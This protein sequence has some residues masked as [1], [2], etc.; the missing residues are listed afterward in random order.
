MRV[1]WVLADAVTSRSGTNDSAVRTIVLR[2]N[3]TRG[4]L[5]HLRSPAASKIPMNENITVS[6]AKPMSGI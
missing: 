6:W 4:R 3:A 1:P 5:A 2:R